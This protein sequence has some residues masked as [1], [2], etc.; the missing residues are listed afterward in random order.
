MSRNR[1][2]T[3]VTLGLALVFVVGCHN[4]AAL[5]GPGAGHHYGQ[6]KDRDFKVSVYTDP[7]NPSKCLLD[8]SVGTL[9][10]SKNQT[11]TWFSDDN[12]P[13]TIDFTHGHQGSPFQQPSP[14][15]P[16]PA[17]GSVSSTNLQP[18]ASGYYDFQVYAGNPPT[19]LCKDLTD[20]PGYYV[21]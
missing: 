14:Q 18:N 16:L 11:V 6:E 3:L 13:Y 9:W 8:W 21:K 12:L 2:R 1:I 15:F 4:K 20:D 7:S 17:A 10:K 5:V 19:A